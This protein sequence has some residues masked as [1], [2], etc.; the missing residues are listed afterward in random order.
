VLPGVQPPHHA[1]PLLTEDTPVPDAICRVLE[2]AGIDHVFGMPGGNTVRIF[3]ALHGFRDS[4]RTVLVREEGVGSIMAEVYGRLTGKP[5][6]VMGQGAFVHQASLGAIEAHMGSSPM[7]MLTELTDNAPFTHHA[8]TQSGSGEYGAWDA[9]QSFSAFTKRTMLPLSG[10]QAVQ[11]TQLAIKHA[12]TGDPGPVAVLYHS[13]SLEDTVGPGSMPRLYSTRSYLPERRTPA[14][15]SEVERAASLLLQAE[16]PAIIAGNGVR[17]SRAFEELQ[18]LA[19]ALGAPVATTAEGKGT[20]DETHELALGAMGNFGVPCANAVIS[21][22]DTLLVAGSRL[23]PQDTCNGHP[24]LIDPLRQTLIQIDIE[25][26]HA[27][28][29]FPVENVL[30]GDARQVLSQLLEAVESL[31]GVP[32]ETRQARLDAVTKARERYGYFDEAAL[33][34]E[35]M[36]ILPQRVIKG[37][38]RVL[39]ENSIVTCDAGENRIFM[40]HYYQTK[41]MGG[42]LQ[43]NAVAGMGYA[44]PAALAAKLVYPE[45]EVVAVCSDGGFGIGMNGLM[46]AYEEKIPIVTVVLNNNALGW[47]HHGMGDRA[48]ASEFADFDHAAIARSFGCGGIR[49]EDP[50][51]LD[52]AIAEAV[53]SGVP[54]VV[55]V[56]TSLSESYHR[57]TAPLATQSYEGR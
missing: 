55:D 15:P 23:S 49:V 50:D 38:Q 41:S 52:S 54:F 25:P 24:E 40:T 56:R 43:G 27:S 10:P 26:L 45:R 19:E 21:E 46:T 47:V 51:M 42:F 35:M 53:D 12:V 57:V 32:A 30:I 34:S 20:F 36:P 22:A 44:V 11:S 4:I 31:G 48:V 1:T 7:L 14:D 17:V 39:S 29:T 37:T 13:Q 33:F 9:K 2:E 6:V 28:W 18:V 3:S 8:P 5:G 16:R